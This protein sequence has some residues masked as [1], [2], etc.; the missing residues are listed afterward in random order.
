MGC[1]VLMSK[2]RGWPLNYPSE[3]PA[4][5]AFATHGLKGGRL[6]DIWYITVVMKN[7]SHVTNF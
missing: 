6:E 7:I 2:G 5:I 1:R 3:N 4:S